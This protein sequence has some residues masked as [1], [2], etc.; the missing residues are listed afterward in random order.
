MPGAGPL[1]PLDI[2][3]AYRTTARKCQLLALS[4]RELRGPTEPGLDVREPSQLGCDLSRVA[5]I[6]AVRSLGEPQSTLIVSA[7]LLR[8]AHIPWGADWVVELEKGL[9]ECDTD[10]LVLTPN[11]CRSEWTRLER[12]SYMADDPAGLKR[13]LRPLLLADCREELPRFVKPIQLIDVN[14]TAKFE[15]EYP[16]LCRDLGGSPFCG[17]LPTDRTQLPPVTRRL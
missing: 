16:R 5:R 15:R 11:F 9:D 10:V 7:R 14:T 6:A 4:A 2:V 12:T 13:K 8:A 17:E 3:R 1:C